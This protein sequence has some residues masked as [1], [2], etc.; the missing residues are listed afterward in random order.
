MGMNIFK[1]DRCKIVN[2]NNINYYTIEH[3]EEVQHEMLRL[4][5]IVDSICVKNN[6]NY[7]IDGGTLIGALRHKG[8]I[9]WDD[10]ID[11]ELIKSDYLKLIDYLED[12]CK[13]NSDTYLLFSGN[14]KYNHC[15]NFLAS[16]INLYGRMKGEIGLF[17][18]KLDI[19][20]V[21]V[22]S[23][24]KTEIEHN[25]KLRDIANYYIFGNTHLYNI[26]ELGLNGKTKE[27]KRNFLKWYNTNY[28]LETC[29]GNDTVFRHP[30]YEFSNNA[31]FDESYFFP[32]K[33]VCFNGIMTSVPNK[34]D[35]Y[36]S[37]LYG[38]YMEYPQ[39]IQRA[40]MAYEYISINTNINLIS[41]IRI[42]TLHTDLHNKYKGLF[43]FIK[44]VGIVKF[45][46]IIYER[47]AK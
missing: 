20:P 23:N 11:I 13:N 25:N 22:I 36:L 29:N 37:E 47:Y 39:L 40:P 5:N 30:Y 44:L 18:I 33:R 8:F 46:K 28:G 26:N 31:N 7:W 3:L 19:R 12:Y 14:N 6:I 35:R 10:D 41:N 34:A 42:L 32:T 27:D 4:L 15:C 43:I 1:S 45:I 2:K 9:P 24:N 16:S 38:N 17:P 21:N